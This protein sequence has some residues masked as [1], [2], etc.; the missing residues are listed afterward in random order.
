[1]SWS[2]ASW[3]STMSGRRSR[4]PRSA[5]RSLAA[6]SGSPRLRAHS[7]RAATHSRATLRYREVAHRTDH[8]GNRT[9]FDVV[10]RRAVLLRAPTNDWGGA[11]RDGSMPRSSSICWSA[12]TGV[13]RHGRPPAS[14]SIGGQRCA[15]ARQHYVLVRLDA[16]SCQQNPVALPLSEVRPNI[17]SGCGSRKVRL[18]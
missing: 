8:H 17:V 7:R 16:Q 13:R 1:M 6:G 18:A 3:T 9:V 5:A 14:A 12:W 15:R 10:D 2:S 4:L 11:V